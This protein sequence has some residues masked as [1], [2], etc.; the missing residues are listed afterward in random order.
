MKLTHWLLPVILTALATPAHAESEA[1]K[2]LYEKAASMMER[3]ELKGQDTRRGLQNFRYLIDLLPTECGLQAEADALMARAPNTCPDV[4]KYGYQAERDFELVLK[5]EKAAPKIVRDLHRAAQR[6]EME[7][8]YAL[9]IDF[10]SRGENLEETRIQ[11]QRL[12]RID[13]SYRDVKDLLAQPA[14]W[15]PL[16]AYQQS[17]EQAASKLD[18]YKSAASEMTINAS[19]VMAN[20]LNPI[21]PIFKLPVDQQ[22]EGAARVRDDAKAFLD[23]VTKGLPR[24]R[25]LLAVDWRS[26]PTGTI[27]RIEAGFPVTTTITDGV[28]DHTLTFTTEEEVTFSHG[29]KPQ[30]VSVVLHRRDSDPPNIKL[31]AK[32]KWEVRD[33]Q[34]ASRLSVRPK[35]YAPF[36]N[37]NVF[38]E[39]D[40]EYTAPSKTANIYDASQFVRARPS[41]GGMGN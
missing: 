25:L 4:I 27:L 1:P 2:E 12:A 10:I 15:V 19:D 23:R 11:F 38:A 32:G 40:R 9:G 14:R 18:Y 24:A 8:T 13:P 36:Q 35:E 21:A 31:P 34:W 26:I 28:I 5:R 7:A 17:L 41:V 22:P 3:G 33:L 29:Q 6:E 39:L 20:V 16:G 37:W 30:E